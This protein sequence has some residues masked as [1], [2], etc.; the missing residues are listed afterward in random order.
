MDGA[1]ANQEVRASP[2]RPVIADFCNKIGTFETS[3]DVRFSAAVG[4]EA[5]ITAT[6]PTRRRERASPAPRATSGIT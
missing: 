2:P 4:G 3:G 5:D 6:Q 1:W